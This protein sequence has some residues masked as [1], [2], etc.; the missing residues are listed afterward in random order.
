MDIK[1][2]DRWAELLLDTGKRNY[3]INFRDTKTSTVEIVAPAPDVMWEKVNGTGDLEA[4]D[5]G[6]INSDNEVKQLSLEDSGK[7]TKLSREDYIQIYRPRLKKASQVLLYSLGPSPLRTLQ[8]ID[9]K[10]QSAIEETG[11]NV[12]Y[13]AFGFICWKESDSSQCEYRAPVLLV[14]VQFHRESVIAP[15]H[16]TASSDEIIVNPTFSYKLNAEHGIRLPEYEDEGLDDYLGKVANLVRKLNWSVTKEC[17]IGL[18]SF[19]KMNMYRDLKDHASSILGNR[20]VRALFGEQLEND[21]DEGSFDE[22]SLDYGDALI[23]LH[24][25]VDADSSQIEAIEMAKS[26]VSFVLQGPPGTGK[27]QTITNIIA[28]CLNDGKRVLFVSEKLAALNVV[29]DK[30]RQAELSDFCLELHSYKANRKDVIAELCRTLRLGKTTVSP[31]ADEEVAAKA[32]AQRQLDLYAEELHSQRPGIE[33]SLY[34]LYE[35]HSACRNIPEFEFQIMDIE[36]KDASYLTS[37]IEFLEQY[38]DYLPSVGYDYHKNPWYG[39]K[40]QDTSYQTTTQVKSDLQESIRFFQ[41]LISVSDELTDKYGIAC[42]GIDA[43]RFWRDFLSFAAA[44]GIITPAFLRDADL[45]DT[46]RKMATLSAEILNIQTNLDAVYGQD[47]Y[48]IDGAEYHQKLKTQFGSF[49]SR[50]FNQEYRQTIASFQ[51]CKRSE[52]KLSYQDAVALTGL[53]SEYRE[54]VKEFETFE[55]LVKENL[56]SGYSG[57][58]SDWAYIKEQLD[59]IE[60]FENKGYRYGRLGEFSLTEFQAQQLTFKD[61]AERLS[62]C[63]DLYGDWYDRLAVAFDNQIFDLSTAQNWVALAKFEGCQCDADKI[64]NWCR[65]RTLLFQLRDMGLLPF[66]DHVI[67]QNYEAK[68]MVAAYKRAFFH[69]WIDCIITTTPALAD[70]NRVMQDRAVTTFS[71]KDTL[72]FEISKVQIRQKLSA[73]RPSLDMVSSGSAVSI[74]L[75]EG[76]KKR[77]QKNIR[78]LLAETG[79]LIQILKPCFMMSPLSV[80]TFLDSDTIHFDT[81]IFDEASQIFPQDAVGAIYRGK[82]LIVVGDSKQMPPSNFFSATVEDDSS[83][84]EAVDVTDFESILDMCST[85]MPQKRLRWHYRSRYEQ[86]IAFSNRNF[87]DGDLITFPSATADAHGIGVDYYHVDGLFD[88]KSH[89]NRKEAEFVVDLIFKHIEEHPDRSLGVVAF[90]VA[91]QELIDDLLSKRRQANPSTENFFKGEHEEPFFVKNLETVQGDERDTIVFS[92]AYGIDSQGRLLHNF[93]PLNRVGGERRLNVA[94]TRAKCNVQLVSSMHYTDIDL[95][96]TSSTGAALLRAYLDYAENGAIALERA[97]SVNPFE[98]FDSEFEMEVCDFL[99][100]NGFEVDTQVGCSG[101]RIDLGLRRS[102][103]SDYLLAIECDGATYHS[104]KNARDRDRL[105]QEILEHMGWKFYRIWSTDWFKNKRV[106]KERLLDVAMRAMKVPTSAPQPAPDIEEPCAEEFEII[107]VANDFK[108]QEYK[109]ADIRALSTQYLPNNFKGMVKAILEIEAPLSEDLLLKRTVM[110]FGREKVTSVV[111]R[112]YE[113]LMRGCERD[114]IIFR[115]GFLYL[116]GQTEFSFRTP[117]DDLKRDIRDICLEE[118]AAGLLELIRQNVTADR[119]GLYHV[120]AGQC[121]C[122]RVGKAINERFDNALDLLGDK[123]NVDGDMISI[124]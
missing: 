81:V 116:E 21:H 66:V 123:I 16:I 60:S 73:K 36:A 87:Y 1:K 18:F 17:K 3:L 7:D 46:L 38:V 4:Y 95:S 74:L 78:A 30:L 63:I 53:L 45:V 98:Q 103:G 50:I 15:Y 107:S 113:Q 34:Q 54:K 27:S 29:Y 47:I 82:Q 52:G 90:S 110:Y 88:R 112:T 33:R 9:K 117:S 80:S 86:L 119:A 37:A 14:P 5:P 23:Q 44:S 71:Q 58:Q 35:A 22:E 62:A 72:Q 57:L 28:E 64:D 97:V 11:V 94:V 83:D 122:S 10:A 99:R 105:R 55:D 26:G 61:F 59:Q 32:K 84:E 96:R 68:H 109:T 48:Q 106:E 40:N 13:M 121:G 118:L 41:T 20:N 42:E 2:L 25:V 49:F 67:S 115:D 91:Q 120:F 43:A 77:R 56:G 124:K 104:S 89:T 100:E 6:I 108:F 85:T 102:G 93:G 19:L 111:Q 76:E 70:F 92:V 8:N 39:Y 101:F 65:F 24:S 31:K 79:E 51:A 69:Q 75:R 114:G 12:A